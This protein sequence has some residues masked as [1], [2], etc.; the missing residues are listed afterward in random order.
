[1]HLSFKKKLEK[2]CPHVLTFLCVCHSSALAAHAAYSK[3]SAYC[4]EFL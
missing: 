1:K 2:M 4:D 3:M